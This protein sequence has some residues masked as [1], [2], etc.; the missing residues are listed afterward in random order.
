MTRSQRAMLRSV[1][2][3]PSLNHIWLSDCLFAYC[4]HLCGD[5]DRNWSSFECNMTHAAVQSVDICK[6]TQS[7]TF[8]QIQDIF[9]S[10]YLHNSASLFELFCGVSD[11]MWKRCLVL[12]SIIYSDLNG[13]RRDCWWVSF[14]RHDS[15]R[16]RWHLNACRL[17]SVHR[18]QLTVAI[19]F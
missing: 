2:S 3:K 17:V 5:C 14:T 11:V 1:E 12:T 6:S 15:L 9:R 10:P 13:S 16:N 4:V 18:H 7:T 8:N 19:I